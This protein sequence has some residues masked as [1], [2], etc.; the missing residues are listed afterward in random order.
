MM[1]EPELGHNA[2]DC[3]T[4]DVIQPVLNPWDPSVNGHEAMRSCPVG[5]SSTSGANDH[6]FEPEDMERRILELNP[7]GREDPRRA[8]IRAGCAAPAPAGAR[9]PCG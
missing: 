9:G 3:G 2:L 1:I 8:W 4:H 7:T 6:W 5:F